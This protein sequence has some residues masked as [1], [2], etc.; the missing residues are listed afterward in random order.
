[1]ALALLTERASSFHRTVPRCR[2]ALNHYACPLLRC[3]HDL[4]HDRRFGGCPGSHS[5]TRARNTA[6]TDRFHCADAVPPSMRLL[7]KRDQRRCPP[8]QLAQLLH[9]NLLFIALRHRGVRLHDP[10]PGYR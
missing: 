2:R 3:T 5:T 8:H 1:M 9:I 4:A 10:E 6:P 7:C